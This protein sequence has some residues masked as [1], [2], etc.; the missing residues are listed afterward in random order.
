MRAQLIVSE[1]VTDIRRYGISAFDTSP[2]YGPSEIILGN[3]LE[4]LKHEFPRSSYQLVRAIASHHPRPLTLHSLLNVAA[5]ETRAPTSTSPEKGSTP[6][7]RAAWPGYIQ[8]TS[9]RYMCT[10]SSSS[11]KA[12][13]RGRRDIIY[14]HL[15]ANKMRTALEKTKQARCWGMAIGRCWVLL[16]H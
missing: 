14:R 12:A 9:T 15:A 6:A 2:Y 4:A 1:V 10:T 8:T 3:A 5:S 13:R 11:R 7:S 16:R